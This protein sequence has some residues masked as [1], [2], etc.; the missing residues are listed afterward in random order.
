MF[1]TPAVS[2]FHRNRIS[3]LY[4]QEEKLLQQLH[5]TRLNIQRALINHKAWAHRG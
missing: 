1:L 4:T 5:H 2:D 3:P